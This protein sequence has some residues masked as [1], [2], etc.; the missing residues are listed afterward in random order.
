[1]AH[2]LLT[3][4][5]QTAT[6]AKRPEEPLHGHGQKEDTASSDPQQSLLKALSLLRSDDW[7]DA[8]PT[9][10]VAQVLHKGDQ[11]PLKGILLCYRSSGELFATFKKDMDSE[12]D[13]VARVLLQTV[14][15][16]R[17]FVQ[18]AATQTLG[19]MVANVTP[20]RAMT[21]LMDSGLQ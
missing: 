7:P 20:A 21:A 19:M 12:V 2:P 10:P 18:E 5:S 16:S 9:W 4:T 8:S 1:M 3:V 11:P 6:G 13:G 17:E 15:N 14:W